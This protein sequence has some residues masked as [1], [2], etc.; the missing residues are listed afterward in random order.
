[1]IT[2]PAVLQSYEYIVHKACNVVV[3]L[4]Q[5]LRAASRLKHPTVEIYK[6]H[7]DRLC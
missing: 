6:E 5:G 4:D 7:V 3:A 1:M 2:S